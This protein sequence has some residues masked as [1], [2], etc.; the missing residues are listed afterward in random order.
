MIGST[1]AGKLVADGAS[2]T[3]MDA[4][5]PLYGGNLYNLEEVRDRLTFVHHDIRDEA[6]LKAIVRG[7]EVVFNLA[8]QVSYVRSNKEPLL[9]IDI[10]CRGIINVLEACRTEAPRALVLFSSS[11]FVYGN[12]E[13][14]PVD[15]KHPFNCRS[16]YGIHKLAGEKYHRFYH[17]AY[18]LDSV[19]LRIANPYGPRQQ[20][21]H[22]EWGIVNWF[23]RLALDGQPL[24]VFGS[25][26]QARDYI[27]V[28]DIAEA[29]LAT[30]K[31]PK[32][33]NQ[34]YNVGSGTGTAFVDMARTVATLVPGTEVRQVE[35]PKDRYLVETGDYVSD[36]GKFR[37]KTGWSPKVPFDDGVRR[38]I[39]FYR[40]N[41][42]YYW[43]EA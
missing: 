5:L 13:Y 23:V 22:S 32:S 18:G 34:V 24:T 40:E 41:K 28:D 37:G 1:I 14:N 8:A 20:M 33:W 3:V 19:S 29:F 12:V 27:Y 15:E 10:N 21:K 31:S 25:G 38:T 35:W 4:M 36:I 17:D 6:A 43:G 11:R 9:D 7:K 39:D 30:A 2:V 26:S 42:R 16:V